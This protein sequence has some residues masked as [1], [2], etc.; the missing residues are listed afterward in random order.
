MNNVGDILLNFQPSSF[1][2]KPSFLNFKSCSLHFAFTP[3]PG[4]IILV[5]R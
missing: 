1:T 4:F 2:L 5:I 3:S